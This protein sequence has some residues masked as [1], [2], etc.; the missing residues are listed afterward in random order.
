MSTGKIG[1]Y[2]YDE[3]VKTKMLRDEGIEIKNGNI[4]NFTKKLFVF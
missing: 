4:K 3:N 1:G 2:P